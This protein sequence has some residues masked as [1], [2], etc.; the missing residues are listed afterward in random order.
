MNVNSLL[1][2]ADLFCAYKVYDDYILRGKKNQ[3]K[4]FSFA[5]KISVDFL[6]RDGAK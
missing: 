3:F 1:K 2:V 4:L 5:Y 6:L